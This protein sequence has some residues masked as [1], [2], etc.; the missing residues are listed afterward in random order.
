MIRFSYPQE[1]VGCLPQAAISRGPK[2]TAQQQSDMK[3]T[4]PSAGRYDVQL[5]NNG[6]DKYV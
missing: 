3:L 1:P 6:R 5:C 4:F 2:T